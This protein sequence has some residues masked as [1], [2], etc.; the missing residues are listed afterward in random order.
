[1]TSDDVPAEQRA[2]APAFTRDRR[3]EDS[4]GDGGI[5]LQNVVNYEGFP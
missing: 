4:M 1:M 3:G 2:P 5:P